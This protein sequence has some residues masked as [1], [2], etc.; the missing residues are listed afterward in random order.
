MTEEVESCASVHLSHDPLGSGVDALGP[1]VVV[2]QGE[3]G[4][5]GGAV[6]F[7]AVGEAV[8]V[9]QVGGADGGDPLGEFV[10]VGL[11]R[12]Q[13][14]GELAGR[15]ASA[16]ISGQ[17]AVRRPS[18]SVSLVR[19]CSGWVSRSRARRRG[20]VTGRSPSARPWLR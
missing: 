6:E 12:G 17:A 13:E 10:V 15:R 11:G 20:V 4:V 2:G 18:R 8:Q 16:V 9:G 19:R 14:R 7:E 3:A 5:H 1:A